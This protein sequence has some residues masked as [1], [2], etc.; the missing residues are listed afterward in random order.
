[1]RLNRRFLGFADE[2]DGSVAIEFAMILPVLL[3]LL[4]GTFEVSKYIQTN[5]QVVQV[6]SMVGQMASQLPAAAKVADVQRIWSAAPLIAA[7]AQRVAVRRKASR[8][9]DVLSLT[10][11][12]IA[13]TK[14]IPSCQTDCQY[15]GNV[16]WSVGQAPITCGKIYRGGA[17]RP[18]SDVIPDELYGP[19]SVLHVRASLPYEPYLTGTASFLDGMARALTTTMVESSWF[20]PR[21]ATNI[22]L[23]AI[24]A[25]NPNFTICPG[26]VP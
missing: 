9:S 15:D 1:M 17:I 23:S 18:T 16:S 5:N 24:G 26:V 13:F 8:W 19:G 12:S 14:R 10:I 6:V 11:T 4:L 2:R 21:N 22:A 7:E 20:L 3:I 25:P